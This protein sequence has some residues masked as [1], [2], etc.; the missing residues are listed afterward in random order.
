MT[1]KTSA[2]VLVVDD[3]E[4]ILRFLSAILE[5]AGFT[6]D[7][8][9]GGEQAL[10]LVKQRAPDLISLDLVM[11]RKGGA[12]FLYSLRKNREWS[13]IPVLVVT[14][15][16]RD[17]LGKRDLEDILAGKVISGPAVYLE[18]PVTPKSYVAAVKR[19]LGLSEDVAARVTRPPEANMKQEIERQLGNADPQTLEEVLKVLRHGTAPGT[20]AAEELAGARVLVIDDEPDVAS[21]LAALLTDAGYAVQTSSNVQDALAQAIA[22]PP[23]LITLDVDMPGKSGVRMYRDLKANASLANVP[24]I[25]ITGIQQDLSALF[26]G[27]RTVPDV[28]GYLSKPFDPAELH[29]TVKDAL[30]SRR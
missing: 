14:G 24:V 28:D 22:D 9:S 30:R 10:E 6:V 15:H 19:Q 17:D 8:A 7:T 2:R 23:D 29:A 12:K 27:K 26:T 4:D 16:A 20:N 13:K 3:E 21:Y 11:P 25:V 1:D 5:D 18:K